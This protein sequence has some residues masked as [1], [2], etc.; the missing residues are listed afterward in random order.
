M[1]SIRAIFMAAVV[2]ALAVYALDCFAGSTP[3]EAMECCGSMGC[4]QPS[5]D[6]SQDCCQTMSSSHAPFVQSHSPDASSHSPM[7][8]AMALAGD[9]LQKPSSST[10][11]LLA[12]HCNAPPPSSTAADTPIRV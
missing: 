8:V 2:G 3:D 11:V 6:R 4:P 9:G 7:L 10:R 5:H 1:R 12:V